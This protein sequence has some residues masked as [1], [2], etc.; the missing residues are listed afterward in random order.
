MKFIFSL[1][2]AS[3]I[4]YNTTKTEAKD[5]TSE[6]AYYS[7]YF[8][9]IADDDTSP[10][11]IPLDLNWNPTPNGYEIEF[12]SW[13]GTKKDW[14]II[15][16][17]KMF[18]NPIQKT[19]QESFQHENIKGFLF[20][21]EKKEITLKIPHVPKV[22]I[23][24][25]DENNWILAPSK[26]EIHK[27]TYACKTTIKIKNET[28]KGWIIYERIRWKKDEIVEFGDF[29]TFLWI[30]LIVNGD[31][32]HFEQHKDE[33][34]AFKWSNTNGEIKVDEVSDFAIKVTQTI[35]DSKSGRKDIP[36]EI[37]ISSEKNNLNISL[38][39]KGEQVGHGKK[40]PKGLAYYR[41]SLLIS[42]NKDELSGYG[43]LEL[44][45]ENN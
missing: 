2:I 42:N 10:L 3:I 44:I 26:N 32:Y 31:L 5:Y 37:N 36:K 38:I 29:E 11:V 27:E 19:P 14:P 30:P 34:I 7:D 18:N 15:Y 33:K 43:M 9:F 22:T 25:P 12:K 24:I 39:S 45:I 21:S 8:V 20:N 40:Y 41:Q 28:K 13:Y 16:T 4:S 6:F 1:L 17:K 35:K 23:T